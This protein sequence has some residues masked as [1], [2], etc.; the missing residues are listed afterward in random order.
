MI[1]MY[2]T[3]TMTIPVKRQQKRLNGLGFSEQ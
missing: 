3:S 2:L 1:T